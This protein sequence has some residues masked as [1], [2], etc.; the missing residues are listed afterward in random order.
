MPH[1]LQL[2]INSQSDEQ[3]IE[4]EEFIHTCFAKSYD[5]NIQ[6]FMPML[7][8]VRHQQSGRLLAALG[9]RVADNSNLYLEKYLGQSAENILTQR[10]N[11]EIKRQQIVE[12]GNLASVNTKAM[13]WLFLQ[14]N[15]YLYQQHY[16]WAISTMIPKLHHSFCRQGLQLS[17][18]TVA[19][20]QVLT[21]NE[22]RIWGR[23]YEKSP[24]VVAGNITES[25]QQFKQLTQATPKLNSLNHLW[26]QAVNMSAGKACPSL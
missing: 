3:R 7:I 18:L 24:L 11:Q 13:Q 15:A 12:I 23:Y 8:A 20:K 10:F 21:F 17:T 22:Q 9:V 2:C 1:S 6:S 19:Q 14:A 5:A 26:H 25:Y 16:Q 4:I